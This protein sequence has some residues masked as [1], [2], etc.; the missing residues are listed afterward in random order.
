MRCCVWCA[1]E[2]FA[3]RG[4]LT[5]F[6][7]CL[8]RRCWNVSSD[9]NSFNNVV[10]WMRQIDEHAAENVNR[11][12][13]GN[14]CDVDASQRVRCFRVVAVALVAFGEYKNSSC[15]L[16]CFVDDCSK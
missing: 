14:K 6:F 3:F 2:I 4:A 12:L 16:L 10:N 13:V 5:E 15:D 9:Q 8:R 1:G 7:L 11:V